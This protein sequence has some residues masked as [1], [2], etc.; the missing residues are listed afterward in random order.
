M[1]TRNLEAPAPKPTAARTVELY[2]EAGYD[3]LVITNHYHPII[4]EQIWAGRTY[5][6]QG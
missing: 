3:A 2:A 1:C 6:E 4:M 5:Q